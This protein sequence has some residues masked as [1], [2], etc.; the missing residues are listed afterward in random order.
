[1]VRCKIVITLSL[2]MLLAAS[3]QT[4]EGATEAWWGFTPKSGGPGT[5]I[6][7]KGG[8]WSI[9]EP[10]VAIYLVLP[11]AT[12][13]DGEVTKFQPL[14]DP[15]A[16]AQLNASD[17]FDVTAVIPGT[18]PDGSHITTSNLGLVL[19]GERTYA[20]HGAHGRF[21]PF[22]FIPARLPGSG[23]TAAGDLLLWA[24]YAGMVLLVGVSARWKGSEA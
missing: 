20:L 10:V 6:H 16:T 14:G 21:R 12:N 2:C 11:L 7:A 15:L 3:L 24:T 22:T 13:Q 1:M 23:K 9:G 18:M 8:H 4:A 5:V 17:G 19:M